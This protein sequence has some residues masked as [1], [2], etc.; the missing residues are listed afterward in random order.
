MINYF[1]YLF[2]LL[3]EALR[4]HNNDGIVSNFYAVCLYSFLLCVVFFLV[5][6]NSPYNLIYKQKILFVNYFCQLV[7][8]TSH[9]YINIY[10][11]NFFVLLQEARRTPTPLPHYNSD[12]SAWSDHKTASID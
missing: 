7:N 2:I 6:S 11:I 1:I 12:T 4:T 9:C 5:F 3:Q 10:F 8:I